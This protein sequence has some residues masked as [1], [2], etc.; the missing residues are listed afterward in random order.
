MLINIIGNGYFQ[1][2]LTGTVLL[3][4]LISFISLTTT[5]HVTRALIFFFRGQYPLKSQV[6]KR[7][8]LTFLSGSVIVSLIVWIAGIARHWVIFGNV[9]YNMAGHSAS[10]T[11][12]KMTIALSVY[13]FDFI[14]AAI[15]LIFF[16]IIYETL[17]FARDS[18][19][20]QKRLR[21]AEQEQEKL[22]AANLQSQLDALKQQVNPHFLFNSLNVL[23]SLIED[24]PKQAR[25]FLEELS[26][27]YRYLLRSNQ[28]TDRNSNLT[29]LGTEL[30]FIHSYF[31]LLKTRHGTGLHLHIT[32]D[33][34]YQTYQ[35][36]PLTLQLLVENAVKHNIVLPDQPLYIEIHTDER[37][38]LLVRNN[39][40]RKTVRVASNGIGLA[41]ILSKY[42]MLN[43][44]RPIIR[45]AGGEFVVT[46]PLIATSDTLLTRPAL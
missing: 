42:Q 2:P 32:I 13:G 14:D 17:F 24:D 30:D 39:I 36:P 18:S 12:N 10:I 41:N 33:D 35:L 45:E 6:L 25:V 11:V 28:P 43:Q 19:F 46:L 9:D 27:V 4:I 21:Q 7:L 22:R 20:Y 40:Q 38:Q 44:P 26:T 8:L 37:A 3:R 34:R 31:H 16:Q 5:W 15:N 1:E 23:D 29:E